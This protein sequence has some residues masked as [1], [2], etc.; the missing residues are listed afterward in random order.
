VRTSLFRGRYLVTDLH[1]TVCCHSCLI[2]IKSCI[3]LSV[4]LAVLLFEYL[5]TFLTVLMR[6]PLNVTIDNHLWVLLF[7]SVSLL[8]ILL[9][10]LKT[11]L[12]GPSRVRIL[13]ST[14]CPQALP[15]DARD[16][17]SHRYKTTDEPTISKLFIFYK[18][19][20]ALL[21]IENSVCMYMFCWYQAAWLSY[22][23]GDPQLPFWRIA[24]QE[25][26]SEMLTTKCSE[27]QHYLPST[28]QLGTSGP[29]KLSTSSRLSSH[30]SQ[31][32]RNA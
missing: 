23:Q 19:D 29:T 14:P 16:Q 9:L 15:V 21:S 1:A 32:Q 11:K 25:A 31:F 4:L 30:T 7:V 3:I 13:P 26:P 28:S 22:P 24:L 27:S 8:T 6:I 12:L 10:R 17:H 5:N 2:S 20:M 18:K